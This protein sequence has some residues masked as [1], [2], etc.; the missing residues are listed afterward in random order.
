V[1][2]PF[3]LLRVIVTPAMLII[4]VNK[5]AASLQPKFVTVPLFWRAC[6]LTCDV[7]SRNKGHSNFSNAFSDVSVS[8]FFFVGFV[9][10]ASFLCDEAY[11]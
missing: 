3:D 6:F 1:K 9:E 11:S 10:E 7:S 2:D 5:M 8:L 4:I